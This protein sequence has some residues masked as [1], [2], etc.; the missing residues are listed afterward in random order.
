MKFARP[1]N[2]KGKPPL[3][4]SP[5]SSLHLG[6]DYAYPEGEP[7][8]AAADGKISFAKFTETRQWIAN[9]KNDP[10]KLPGWPTPVRAL[11]TEDYGNFVKI[12]HEGGYSTLY[13][14]LLPK[15]R[16]ATGTTVKKGQLIG[17]EGS[18]GN[19]TGNHLH[20]EPRLNE[21]AIDP[22]NMID[23]SFTNYFEVETP[24]PQPPMDLGQKA[25][26]ADRVII[27]DQGP[28]VDSGKFIAEL[29]RSNGVDQYIQ[30]L[31]NRKQAKGKL[32]GLLRRINV[33]GDTNKLTLEDI[34]LAVSTF[35]GKEDIERIKKDIV[36][37]VQG[38]KG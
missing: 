4:S 38:Y 35:Y 30:E 32:D 11:R 17:F 25:S 13:T 29:F 18:T 20:W 37:L 26:F 7:V 16:V 21:R 10:F 36:A 6:V 15:Q 24:Q 31:E 28:Q 2:I 23:E 5:F 19:S 9:G 1:I 12:V 27:K 33:T 8:Y 34:I 22:S 14:H 3:I